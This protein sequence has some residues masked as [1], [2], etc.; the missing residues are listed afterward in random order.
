M[1][2]VAFLAERGLDK[3][4]IA[5]YLKISES[6]FYRRL[7]DEQFSEAFEQGKL[8]ASSNVKLA[9]FKKALDNENLSAL[10]HLSDRIC[11]PKRK[12]ISEGEYNKDGTLP[13]PEVIIVT[14]EM[15]Q[16][17]NEEFDETY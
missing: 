16:A 1:D 11:W 2:N 13:P 12:A 17:F 7:Q 10:F 5:A 9:L 14:D 4:E 6:T 8:R 15:M 3:R